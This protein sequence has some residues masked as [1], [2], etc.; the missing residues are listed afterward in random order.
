MAEKFEAGDYVR[1]P[2]WKKSLRNDWFILDFCSNG[3]E[4][5]LRRRKLNTNLMQTIV[6]ISKLEH[7]EN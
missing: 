1:V 3:G 7:Q 4:A 2:S 6:E 5:I